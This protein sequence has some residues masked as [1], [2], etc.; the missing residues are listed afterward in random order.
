MDTLIQL[1]IIDDLAVQAKHLAVQYH[2]QA[3]KETGLWFAFDEWKWYDD[4]IGYYWA[5]NRNWIPLIIFVCIVPIQFVFFASFLI[6]NFIWCGTF[7]GNEGNA[8]F[9]FCLAPLPNSTLVQA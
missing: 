2:T 6:Y 7:T 4:T 9:N 5:S 8:K 1:P 3:Q